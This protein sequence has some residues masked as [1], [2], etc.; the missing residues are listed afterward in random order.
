MNAFLNR[1]PGMQ[2]GSRTN[3]RQFA[4]RRLC[5]SGVKR[6]PEIQRGSWRRGSMNSKQA[7]RSQPLRNRSMNRRSEG[8]RLSSS[9]MDSLLNGRSRTRG[10]RMNGRQGKQQRRLNYDRMNTRFVT[11]R[12]P[13]MNAFTKRRP[14]VQKRPMTD[15]MSGMNGG[16][17][18]QQGFLNAGERNGKSG[19]Q[20]RT[21][22]NGLSNG[23]S[24]MQKGPMTDALSVMKG[25]A[26]SQQGFTMK[27]EAKNKSK[28]LPDSGNEGSI[29]FKQGI[30]ARS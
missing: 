1:K 22:M 25:S 20:R 2:S 24:T 18:S 23:L 5:C 19:P 29:K 16:A 3:R 12:R 17:K 8:Q 6:R 30:P 13:W 7:L 4:R 9:W 28:I 11:Q 26:K 15:G 27:V 14:G 21:W 10:P